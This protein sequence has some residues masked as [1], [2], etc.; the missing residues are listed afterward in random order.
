MLLQPLGSESLV[1]LILR[2]NAF[3]YKPLIND[4]HKVGSIPTLILFG[5][6]DWTLKLNK[7]VYGDGF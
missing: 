7:A 3:A 5:D 2:S 6:D 1:H 4:L